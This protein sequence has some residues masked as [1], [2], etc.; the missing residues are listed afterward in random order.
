MVAKAQLAARSAAAPSFGNSRLRKLE[1]G[2]VTFTYR[3]YAC[4]GK[5]R[6]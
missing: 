2:Q 6:L 1:E 3:D 4:G 5:E